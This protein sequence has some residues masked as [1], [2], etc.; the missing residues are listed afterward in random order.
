MFGKCGKGACF[1]VVNDM[2]ESGV[3][4]QVFIMD[5]TKILLFHN[6]FL[7]PVWE[8]TGLTEKLHSPQ[9]QDLPKKRPY[10]IPSYSSLEGSQ[11]VEI[12]TVMDECA[13]V[14]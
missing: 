5:G 2:K 14:G 1:L 7:A 12:I 3:L 11:C 13:S 6:L 9:F 10:R 4:K 8:I